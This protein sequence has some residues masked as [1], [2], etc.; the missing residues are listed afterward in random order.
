MPTF[1]PWPSARRARPIDTDVNARHAEKKRKQKAA[2]DR[3][4]ATKTLEK[5]LL[6]VH[7]G[8][9]KD[10]EE[11][12]LLGL[13]GQDLVA[14]RLVDG[15]GIGNANHGSQYRRYSEYPPI[16]PTKVASGAVLLY[17]ACP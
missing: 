14:R 1:W 13:G 17:Q 8:K 5:G 3:M 7:T 10:D 16:A 12:A 2:R 6:I 9:G 11:A 15:D 4:L